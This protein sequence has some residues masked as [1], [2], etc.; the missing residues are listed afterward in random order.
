MSVLGLLMAAALAG[1][2]EA[3]PA[4]TPSAPAA[5]PPASAPG[6]A[7]AKKDPLD[8]VVCQR[9]EETGSRLGGKRV[10]MT[11]RDWQELTRASRDATE[12]VQQ[13]GLM[14]KTPGS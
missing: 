11:R 2:A 9:Q 6:A 5:A 13:H 10:C 14:V 12:S 1:T 4:T 8:E 3:P 7:P